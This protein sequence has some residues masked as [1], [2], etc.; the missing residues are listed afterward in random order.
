MDTCRNNLWK[1]SQTKQGEALQTMAKPILTLRV[2][3]YEHLQANTIDSRLYLLKKP[4][5][6]KETDK[7]K[8]TNFIEPAETGKVCLGSFVANTI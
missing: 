6:M 8:T 5:L 3:N 1:I 2:V 4:D 7:R